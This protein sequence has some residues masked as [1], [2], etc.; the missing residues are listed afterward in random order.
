MKLKMRL[1]LL[2][3]LIVTVVALHCAGIGNCFT[4]ENIKAQRDQ[5]HLLVQ[6]RYLVAVLFYIL[7]LVLA[8]VA[9]L[10]VAAFLTIAAGYFFGMGWGLL[11]VIIG[12]TIG[13]VI[14]FIV[15][16]YLL[17]S[18]LQERYS[19]Q[20]GSFNTAVDNYGT[21][22]LLAIHWV[23]VMPLFVVN[24]LAGLTKVSL[25]SFTWT[26]AVGIIPSAAVYA[27]AGQQLTEIHS[28]RDIF[29]PHVLMAFALL[30]FFAMCSFVGAYWWRNKNKDVQV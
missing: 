30:G 3:L 9:A 26:T 22:Y 18:Y 16:R 6:Q 27:F 5:V 17:G 23:L 29:T 12:A 19:H 1:V 7:I 13:S 24:I 10:P 8:I 4:L 14:S 2:F 21:L 20:L 25:W 28:L 15:T 11:Y